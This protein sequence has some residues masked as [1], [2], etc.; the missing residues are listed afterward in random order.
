M[1]NQPIRLGIISALQQEQNGLVDFMEHPQ[2]S[3]RGMRNYV[4]GTLWGID[5]VCVLSRVGKVAAA[6]TAATLI[7]R[8]GVTHVLFTGVAGGVG[9]EVRVGDVVVADDLVQHDMDARPLFPVFE[10][11]LTGQSRLPSDRHLTQT[12]ARAARRFLHEELHE[13]VTEDDRHLFRLQEPRLHLGLVA[14]GD[15]FIH[16]RDRLGDLRTVLPEVLA[17]EMEGAAVAQVCFEFGLPFA[18][19][20]T[21]SD[22]ANEAAPIDFLQFI[23]RVASRYAVGIVKQVCEMLKN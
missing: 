18:I 11:P 21:I 17:V 22:G 23:D 4:G 10:I 8:F 16:S 2:A 7:E 20:R 1:S 12:V 3:T 9:E 15:E 6:A 14:S 19:I 13:V 5:A